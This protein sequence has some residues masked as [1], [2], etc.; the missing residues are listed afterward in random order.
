MEEE[1]TALDQ[2]KTWNLAPLLEGKTTIGCKWVF[3]IKVNLNGSLA[4]LKT[5]LVAK[6][7][8]QVYGIDCVILSLQWLR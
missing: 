1:L 7:Y 3:T 6:G 8:T 5:R 2:N 4:R